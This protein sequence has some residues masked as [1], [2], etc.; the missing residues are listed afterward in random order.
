MWTLQQQIIIIK[1][2]YKTEIDSLHGL[3]TLS[4]CK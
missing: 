4:Y 2:V 3:R 1:I